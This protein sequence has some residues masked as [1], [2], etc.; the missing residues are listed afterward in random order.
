M[1]H[2]PHAAA[3]FNSGAALGFAV[4]VFRARP[5]GFIALMLLQTAAFTGASMLQLYLMAEPGAAFMTAQ[6]GGDAAEAA[7]ATGPYFAAIGGGLLVTLTLALV[8]E[9]AWLRLFA[10]GRTRLFPTGGDELRL[11]VVFLA[12]YGLVF[13]VYLGA[14]FLIALLAGLL[15][16]VAGTGPAILAGVLGGLA[17]ICAMI[18]VGVRFAP[19]AGLTVLRGRIALTEAFARSGQFFWSLFGAHLLGWLLFVIASIVITV[20]LAFIPGPYQAV[21]F[22]AFNASDPSAQFDAYGAIFADQAAMA[23]YGAVVALQSFLLA[24][25]YA[26]LRGIGVKAALVIDHEANAPGS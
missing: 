1:S 18:W 23:G 19:A 20:P 3:R 26:L 12:V 4:E 13:V 8:I 7:R 9:A 15:A 10:Y 22:S 16:A 25:F 5:I 2:T 21:L 6:L 24:P 11:L 17:A 14:V